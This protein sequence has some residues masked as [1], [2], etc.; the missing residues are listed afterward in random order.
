MPAPAVMLVAAPASAV[1]A[2]TVITIVPVVSP[3]AVVPVVI[4]VVAAA[5]V[6]TVAAAVVVVPVIAAVIVV[7]VIA[8]AVVIPI[9]SAAVAIM[10]V[11][12]VARSVAVVGPV[13]IDPIVGEMGG[14]QRAG[15]VMVV[16]AR[17]TEAVA[18]ASNSSVAD[19]PVVAVVVGRRIAVARR[20]EDERDVR[21]ADAEG[22]ADREPVVAGA[23]RRDETWSDHHRSAQEDD[24]KPLAHGFET[25]W[26]TRPQSMPEELA[27]APLWGRPAAVH[28]RGR[29]SPL[30]MSR[31]LPLHSSPA[32]MVLPRE[33][34]RSRGGCDETPS[35]R[36]GT[37]RRRA[38]RHAAAL[39]AARRARPDRDQVR[40]RHGAM[41]RLYRPPR[42]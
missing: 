4:P 35:Q 6:V 24:R 7:A 21:G 32:M 33:A 5:I 26:Q 10:A 2:I 18:A 20:T 14:H 41:R 17:V 38:G 25:S 11:P 40:L 19:R 1:P 37:R 15:L 29:G 42:R 31:S 34:I 28:S 13:R 8:S 39:G 30:E 22:G 12:I 23:C 9:V 27:G 36:Q 16:V 3:T